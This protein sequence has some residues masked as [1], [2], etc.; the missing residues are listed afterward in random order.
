MLILLKESVK[1]HPSR[2]QKDNSLESSITAQV[3]TKYFVNSPV[4]IL[5]IHVSL[6]RVLNVST[7]KFAN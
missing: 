4:L 5:Y 6:E 3:F 2:R 7:G 1:C